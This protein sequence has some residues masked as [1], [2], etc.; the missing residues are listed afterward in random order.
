MRKLKLGMVK[1]LAPNLTGGIWSRQD[2]YPGRLA[3]GDSVRHHEAAIPE[4]QEV[5]SR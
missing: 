3:L 2:L 1:Q 4:E 5:T